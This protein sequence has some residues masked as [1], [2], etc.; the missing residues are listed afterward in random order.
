MAYRILVIED[1]INLKN[2][3][4]E[5]LENEGYEVICAENGKLGLEKIKK[6][7]PDL[8]ISDVL[9]PEMDGFK[10]LEEMGKNPET[11]SV[12]LIFLTAK[13]EPENL[14]KGMSLGADDYLFKPFHINELL[15]AIK[16]RLKKKEASNQKIKLMQD[17]ITAKIPHELRTPLV[18]ILGFAEL[19]EEE[20]DVDQIKDMAKMIGKSGKLLHG[21]V[22]KFLIYKDLVVKGINTTSN[23]N[24]NVKTG[25]SKNIVNFYLTELPGELKPRERVKVNVKTDS[26]PLSEWTLGIIIKELIENGLRYSEQ[27]KFVDIHGYKENGNYKIVVSD[28]GKGMSANEINSITAFQ[29]FGENQL[30]EPGL[31][32]GLAIINKIVELNHGSFVIN[33]EIGKYTT[34]EVTLPL[35]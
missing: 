5:L 14:R 17:Q 27:D 13:A 11:D 20:E 3:I 16:I 31:G 24:E 7:L 28:N 25:I 1:D 22:E 29:K 35:N 34:C 4:C 19:I 2:N 18:P 23:R 26:I 30:A 32:L 10:V 9:M 33:S 21:R 6:F 12:P 8:I 15:E